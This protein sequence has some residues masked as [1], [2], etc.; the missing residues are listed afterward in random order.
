MEHPFFKDINWDDIKNKRHQMPFKPRV[1][2]AEDTSCIDT[3][4][5]RED[6]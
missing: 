6:L 2:H 5:T 1:K 3:M 4:F